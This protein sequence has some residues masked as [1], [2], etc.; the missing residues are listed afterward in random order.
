[1][2]EYKVR[3]KL[4]VSYLLSNNKKVI[5]EDVDSNGYKVYVFW[6][7]NKDIEDLKEYILKTNKIRNY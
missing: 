2:K 4:V 7:S 3:G 6:L 5:R 1:M